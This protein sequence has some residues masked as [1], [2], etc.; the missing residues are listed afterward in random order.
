M[1]GSNKAIPTTCKICG[2]RWRRSGRPTTALRSTKPCDLAAG[3]ANPGRSATEMSDTQVAEPLPAKLYIFS[4]GR[5]PDVRGFSLGN[6]DPFFEPIG[7]AEAA[8]VGIVG[9]STQRNEDK[10]DQLQAFARLEN[11]GG[12]EAA[13]SLELRLDGNLVDA[14]QVKIP[15]DGSD[16][17]VFARRASGKRRVAAY[18]FAGDFLAQDNEAWAVVNPPRRTHVL[19]ITPGNQPLSRALTVPAARTMVGGKRGRSR[20]FWTRPHIA[21]KPLRERWIW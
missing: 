9:F 10:P 6:L 20:P 11:H 16:S 12:S 15:A 5:F 19:L 13:V 14:R 17:E 3:L 18:A 4:D 2:G 7:D 1:L 8:N 21:R